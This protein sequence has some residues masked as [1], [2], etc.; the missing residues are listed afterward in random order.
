MKFSLKAALSITALFTLYA[1]WGPAHLSEPRGQTLSVS[2][3]CHA[4]TLEFQSDFRQ[5]AD[6]RPLKTLK[7]AT[8]EKL[9]WSYDLSTLQAKWQSN[10]ELAG[11]YLQTR[12][13]GFD[14]K[15]A[16]VYEGGAPNQHQVWAFAAYTFKA[17]TSIRIADSTA[18]KAKIA[19]I[20]V[21]ASRGKQ[22]GRELVG[23]VGR[24]LLK[25]THR[26]KSLKNITYPIWG[27]IT[28][29]AVGDSNLIAFYRK[30]GFKFANAA[31]EHQ[32]LTNGV[33]RS[34]ANSKMV[35]TI[36]QLK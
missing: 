28:L 24:E 2:T 13:R 18:A 17:I 23:E 36:F 19:D 9:S 20:T 15:I 11:N 16:V 30:L 32:Y 29:T 35:L 7:L 5:L 8:Y 31:V 22:W 10:E 25:E 34:T 3:E 1:C 6:G 27:L 26:V 14:R 4:D 21:L 33:L 12:T